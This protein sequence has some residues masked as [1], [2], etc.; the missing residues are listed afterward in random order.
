MCEG[1]FSALR[2][3]IKK[4][5]YGARGKF[6]NVAGLLIYLGR[7]LLLFRARRLERVRM[8]IGRKRA[9]EVAHGKVALYPGMLLAIQS[10]LEVPDT[11]LLEMFHEGRSN[12]YSPL[13]F[14]AA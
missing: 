4:L 11:A 14:N 10:M 7:S 2:K 5:C 1:V 3:E 13:L 8:A 12:F 6:I 9:E